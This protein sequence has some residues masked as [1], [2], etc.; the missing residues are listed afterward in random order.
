MGINDERYRVERYRIEEETLIYM[1]KSLSRIVKQAL[2]NA[3]KPNN[4]QVRVFDI[5]LEEYAHTHSYPVYRFDSD[6][7]YGR[8]FAVRRLLCSDHLEVDIWLTQLGYFVYNIRVDFNGD[9]SIQSSPS[10]LYLCLS[11][12]NE[13]IKNRVELGKFNSDETSYARCC[14]CLKVGQVALLS[15]M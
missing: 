12:Y 2:P 9:T 5:I 15:L 14:R 6:S 4:L 11:C 10:K 3:E 1:A 8:F 13:S 7:E